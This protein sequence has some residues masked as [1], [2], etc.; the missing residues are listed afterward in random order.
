MA[1]AGQASLRTQRARVISRLVAPAAVLMAPAAAAMVAALALAP[2][3]AGAEAWLSLERTAA[4][5]PSGDPIWLL[6]LRQ[7]PRQLASWKA[8]SGAANR[9]QHD[10][11]W[12]PGNAAP[13]PPGR[14][15][16][17]TPEPWGQDLWIDLEPRFATGRSG[18]GIHHCL[19][20]VGCI[21]LPDRRGLDGLAAAIRRW[22]VRRLEVLH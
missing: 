17:G 21:C 2:G 14:Y 7:G 5:F 9:Q 18:L 12:S 4:R 3:A 13:L 10:R 1:E 19:P 20:G 16:V 11:R 15:R 22:D 6:K 8:A